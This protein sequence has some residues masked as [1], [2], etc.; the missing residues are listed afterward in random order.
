MF[1]GEYTH[2]IDQKGRLIIPSKFR[3]GLGD[4]FVITKGLDGCLFLFPNDKWLQF[5]DKLRQLPISNKAVRTF[6]RFFT[7]GG[8][9]GTIDKQ[10]RSLIP[11][12]L[13]DYAQLE[14]EVVII[15]VPDRVEIW[16]KD[17]WNEYIDDENLSH[18]DIASQMEELGF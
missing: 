3:E 15:G 14:K 9:D 16:S 2:N 6:V 8:A 4:Q 11:A 1:L 13:R 5:E 7:A 12:N 17:N 10:G 18:E